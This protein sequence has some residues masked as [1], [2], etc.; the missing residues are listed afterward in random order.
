M[1]S[2]QKALSITLR[3]LNPFMLL[4]SFQ[5]PMSDLNAKTSNTE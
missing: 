5:N 1:M 3:A 2:W 4:L